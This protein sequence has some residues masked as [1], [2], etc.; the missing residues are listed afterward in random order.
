MSAPVNVNEKTFQTEVASDT[1]LVL[2]D[3]WAPWCGPC[4]MIAPVLEEIANEYSGRIKVAKVN[5]DENQGLA[6]KFGV[7]SIPSLLFFRAGEVVDSVVGAV[8]KNRLTE[9]IEA[10]TNAR[11]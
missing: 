10:L 3:F 2:V 8:P 1:G 7:R 4:R 9:K 11:H 6:N 5:V